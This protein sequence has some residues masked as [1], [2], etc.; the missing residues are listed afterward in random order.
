MLSIIIPVFNSENTISELCRKLIEEINSYK[1]EIILINDCSK[2]NSEKVCIELQKKFAEIIKFYSLAKNVG[3]HNAVMAGLN[4]STGD[5]AIIM[6]DDFQNPVSE[7]LKLAEYITS[8]DFDVVYTYYEKKKHNFFRNIGS[9]FNDKV[10]N[11]MLRKPKNLYLSSFKAI[12]RFLINEVVKYD[13]PF[14]YLDGLIL[15]T[16]DK[17]GKILVRH[18]IRV[19]GKSGYTFVKLFAL[20]MNMFTNFSILPLRLSIYLGFIMS[21]FGFLMGIATIIMKI[22]E[23]TL[24]MGYASLMFGLS[25][26]SGIQLI[27]IGMV[28]EYLGR[29]FLSINRTPQYSIRKSFE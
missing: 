9:K 23:P 15:R 21:A 3:E 7:V 11:F 28:G 8:N 24:P 19:Q 13:L 12:N 29:I 27:A 17:I 6:D 10:S 1:L 18:D 14:P 20:W 22:N 5:F 26:F 4:K 2:D 25:I 16:T